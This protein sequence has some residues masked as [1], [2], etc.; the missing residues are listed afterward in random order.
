M[1]NEKVVASLVGKLSWQ[2]DHRPL[3]SFEKRLDAIA[4]KMKSL[5]DLAKGKVTVNIKL[6]QA[7]WNKKV[8]QLQRTSI[9][10]SNISVASGSLT[11]VRAK[12]KERLDT[13]KLLFKEVKISTQSL[14]AM[15]EAVRTSLQKETFDINVMPKWKQALDSLRTWR[16]KIEDKW[17]IR[18]NATINKAKF[19]QNAKAVVDHVSKK[20]GTI[21]ITDPKIKLTVDRTALRAEIANV[22]R[23][24]ERE[25]K[26]R[27][28]LDAGVSGGGGGGG[29][30]GRQFG[31][32]QGMMAGGVAGTAATWGRGFIPGLSGAFAVSH[33]NTAIQDMRGQDL[34][35]QA[36]TGSKEEAMRQKAWMENLSGTLG[37]VTKDTLPA[38][39]KMLASGSTS[40]YS[41]GSVQN[42]FT[43]VSAY[44][45]TMGLDQESMKG[46]F[47][48]I[49]QMINKGQ[50]YSEEL[51]GQLAERAPGVISAMAE[52]AGLDPEKDPE[53]VAKLFK[54]MEDGELKSRDV[55]E[56]FSAILLRRAKEG[57]A[58]EE[59]MKSVAAEQS[60]FKEAW[61][62]SVMQFADA[63]FESAM[64]EFFSNTAEEITRA[65]PLTKSF[66]RAF[67]WMMNPINAAIEVVG[68]FGEY[69]PTLAKGLGTTENALIAFGTVALINLTPIGRIATAIGA[70]VLAVEDLIRYSEGKSSVFGDWLKGLS[71]ED[72]KALDDAAA[73]LKS[74]AE[75]FS[76]L[77]TTLSSTEVFKNIS[78]S[79]RGV[80][81]S[82]GYMAE[83]LAY[84]I[85][86]MDELAQSKERVDV[87]RFLG[88]PFA[89]TMRLWNGATSAVR[90]ED[91][92]E[93]SNRMSGVQSSSSGR[94]GDFTATG[95]MSVPIVQKPNITVTFGNI[96]VA[97]A[98][99][100]PAALQKQIEDKIIQTFDRGMS[101]SRANLGV[102]H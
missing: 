74:L 86:V 101:R 17:T 41:T 3:A 33:L 24:I 58:L 13:T 68:K 89:E 27:I 50:I 49:E 44:G 39:T 83:K 43:G 19:Y 62:K 82:I 56:K 12:I 94:V 32:R 77:F 76:G 63:G 15:R 90:A 5:N 45:R 38:Y 35:L 23:E 78:P 31:M 72:R 48:A 75:A 99:E 2:A 57:G 60:R 85:R 42:I 73:S 14:V 4:A 96:N 97:N 88:N 1:A 79:I 80:A 11:A 6:N 9:Q 98:S 26:I 30:S 91:M 40:G 10:L 20:I 100:I 25:A 95:G 84:L 54:M 66:G 81:G 51:K 93:V 16:K 61:N 34:A 22:L 36:V 65:T 8:A 18:F 37:L 92:A 47:R 87:L 102:A 71:E 55:M 52:A 46:T 7:A 28:K 67:E 53:A 70:I 21:K 64:R 59:A 69:L 29:G